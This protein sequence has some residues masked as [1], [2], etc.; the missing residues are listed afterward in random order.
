[1]KDEGHWFMVMD[2]GQK[3]KVDC[4]WRGKGRRGRGKGRKRVALI[5][6]MV[7]QLRILEYELRVTID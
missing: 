5:L 7:G 2:E 6:L 3:G 1:M 4:G